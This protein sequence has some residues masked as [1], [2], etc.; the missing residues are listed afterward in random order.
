[1]PLDYYTEEHKAFQ[2]TVRHFF[3]KEVNPHIDEWEE[4]EIFPAHQ[5]FK[6]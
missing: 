4:Q 6:R 5:I 3:E 2:R 1:M